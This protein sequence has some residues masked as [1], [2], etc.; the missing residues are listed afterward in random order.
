[1]LCEAVV[2][3]ELVFADNLFAE[4]D[5]ISGSGITCGLQGQE[6]VVIV[7][8]SVIVAALVAVGHQQA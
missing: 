5:I 6:P 2:T 7:S 8:R 4:L 3:E 1:M